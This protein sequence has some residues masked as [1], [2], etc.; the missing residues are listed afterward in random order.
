MRVLL[1]FVLAALFLVAASDQS[2]R[3]IPPQTVEVVNG[4]VR[5]KAY[6]WKPVGPGPF[7][8]VAFNHGRGNTPQEH[9]SDL[10][11]TEAAQ[12]LG[13]V[14]VKHGYVFLYLFRRGEGLSAGQGAFIGDV[15]QREEAAKGEEARR[16]L[17]FVL[18]TTDH[19]DDASAGLS[20][21]KNL[22]EVD[23]HRVA[24]A[25]HS[26]GGQLTMLEAERDPT[27]RAAV[28]FGAA[29]NSWD[30]SAEIRARLLEA[31]D[32]ITVPVLL[33]HAANDYSVTPGKSMAAEFARF[34]KPCV[35]K[36][37]PP[38]GQTES[39]GHNFLYTD[40]AL[41]EDDV[42]KFLDQ[43]LRLVETVQTGDK[44]PN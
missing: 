40:V 31:V 28:T 23:P 16:H 35:L 21:V 38:V 41:W 33:M 10:T 37:Y 12:I 42:F 43:N 30:S 4:S 32:K 19:L 15:L 8:A 3:T 44:A 11:I 7:P 1:S 27:V 5:L 18:M 39:D 24:V 6:L 29:A 34:S 9:T 2:S 13:P 14:F 36:I 17:Q 26:F 20:F 22:P 25:G